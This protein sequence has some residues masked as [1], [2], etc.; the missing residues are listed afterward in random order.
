MSDYKKFI[1]IV[2][3]DP[4]V[5][6]YKTINDEI[7]KWHEIETY[8]TLYD[9]LGIT[10]KEYKQYVE[11]EEHLLDIISNH[12]IKDIEY[13]LNL[14]YTRVLIEDDDGSVFAKIE[15]LH[16][17][18]TVG[19]N[20]EDALEMLKDALY[21]WLEVALKIGKEIPEPKI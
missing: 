8:E 6:I 17:C 21:A 11:N 16:G 2:L 14:P 3:T 4:L 20:R 18:M 15:E 12:K 7:D 13:Y 9:F 5:D 1:D 10:E 19:D